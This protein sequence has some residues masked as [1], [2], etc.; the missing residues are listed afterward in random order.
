[1]EPKFAQSKSIALLL[2][3]VCAAWVFGHPTAA[4]ATA[5]TRSDWLSP[6]ESTPAIAH[7]YRAPL[8]RFGA[9]H[10][11]VDYRVKGKT[12][13]VAPADG[14]IAWANTVA[15]Q[16]T[17][18]IQHANG[19]RTAYQPACTDL[20]VGT[21]VSKGQVFAMVCDNIPAAATAADLARI[22]GGTIGKV[23]KVVEYAGKAAIRVASH[24]SPVLC[25]HF[26]LRHN[27]AYLSPLSM[28]GGLKP[29]RLVK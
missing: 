11:G 21:S 12:S 27:G 28:I 7:D 25:L 3:L 17:V 23:G 20:A 16:P 29:S 15:L 19:Y 5:Q 18:S 2:A 22:A 24:C 8:T 26:S 10:R 13:L 4:H 6:L 1:M 14:V 9:G